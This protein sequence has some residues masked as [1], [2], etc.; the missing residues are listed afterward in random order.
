MSTTIEK[1]VRT[2]WD[3]K[4]V[5]A[6]NLPFL[7]RL[8]FALGAYALCLAAFTVFAVTQGADPSTLF[9]SM[10]ESSVLDW[11]TF[12]QTLVRSV[13]IALAALACTIPARAGMVNVGGEGQIIIGSVA[14]AG[15]AITVGHS[16]TGPTAWLLIAGAA[17]VAGGLWAGFC[18]FLKV[19][20]N[21]SESV[22]TLFLNFIAVDI[23]LFAIYQLWRNGDGTGLP[24]TTP[25]TSGQMLPVI[26]GLNLNWSVP[27]TIVV[28]IGV[29]LLL[30]YSRWGF[31]LKVAGGNVNAAIRAGQPVR[32]IIIT[33]MLVG[34]GLAGLG[35]ALNLM[36]VEGALRPGMTLAFGY[37]AFL[38]N[39]L[40]RSKPL[41]VFGAALLFSAIAM[42]GNGLQLMEGLDGSAVNVLLGLIVLTMLVVSGRKKEAFT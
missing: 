12:A 17:V 6:S 5:I 18:G 10:F 8:G 25:L 26:D 31:R 11:P 39:F 30:R 1:P 21:A 4:I 38:A 34:G 20:M 19:H 16:L 7:K 42:S 14:A 24:E 28:V 37:I 41:P 9:T 22:T 40:G 32:S 23:M 29:A 27:I 15:V 36:G 33:S 13:P 2:T 3:P 35:G